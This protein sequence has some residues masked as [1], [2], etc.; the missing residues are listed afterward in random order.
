MSKVTCVNNKYY[1]VIIPTNK[2]TPYLF[3]A[4]DSVFDEVDHYSNVEVVL[5][6]NGFDAEEIFTEI[7]NTYKNKE[8]LILVR[9]KAKEIS[10]ALNDGIDV[11]NGDILIRFD[12]DDLWLEG[13][14]KEII[15]ATSNVSNKYIFGTSLYKIIDDDDNYLMD[16]RKPLSID[17]FISRPFKSYSAHPAVFF[18]RSVC[19]RV[20]YSPEL[21]GIEDVVF[22]HNI[23]QLPGI[24]VINI[25]KHLISYRVHNEQYT[26]INK[27]NQKIRLADYFYNKLS[28]F[29]KIIFWLLKKNIP[30]IDVWL[31]KILVISLKL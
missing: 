17:K 1:S 22:M 30:L 8:S 31:K 23:L 24:E 6:V 14:L 20:K 29:E 4:L 25:D 21:A 2:V 10:T 27:L 9:S 26:S 3:K 12:S 28:V 18:S 5:V 11:A 13:R 16:G 15:N 7:E 19:K